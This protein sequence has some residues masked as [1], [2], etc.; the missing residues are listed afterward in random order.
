MSRGGESSLKRRCCVRVG[1][2]VGL[3]VKGAVEESVCDSGL[4]RATMLAAPEASEL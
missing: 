2:V 3:G 4:A 1:G